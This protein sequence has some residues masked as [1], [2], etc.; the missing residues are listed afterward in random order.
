MSKQHSSKKK[1]KYVS[2]FWAPTK[3]RDL[4]RVM[5]FKFRNGSILLEVCRI[6]RLNIAEAM[7]FMT[8]KTSPTRL[9]GRN[10]LV[11][12]GPSKHTVGV[13]LIQLNKTKF[14]REG[15]L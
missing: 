9:F 12:F 15:T 14:K 7:L 3:Q 8:N 13:H 2:I 6:I 10:A 11:T 5:G 4:D 1:S